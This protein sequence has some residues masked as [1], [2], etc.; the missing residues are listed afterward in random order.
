[1]VNGATRYRGV[2]AG[3]SS[4]VPKLAFGDCEQ[5]RL[6]THQSGGL[7]VLGHPED[8]RKHFVNFDKC[9]CG[10]YQYLAVR[11]LR[12]SLT[13]YLIHVKGKERR[14]LNVAHVKKSQLDVHGRETAD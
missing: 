6:G 14:Y 12:R 1:M 10:A 4:C 8:K 2:T 7:K 13:I 11:L 3:L 9:T 5:W